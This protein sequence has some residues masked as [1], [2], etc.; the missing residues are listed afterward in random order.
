LK[1]T[2]NELS[3][4]PLSLKNGFG[5]GGGTGLNKKLLQS[6]DE[7]IVGNCIY[8]LKVK[9]ESIKSVEFK[10]VSEK[11]YSLPF[12]KV[13]DVWILKK[14]SKSQPLLLGCI[15]WCRFYLRIETYDDN[16]RSIDYSYSV[17]ICKDDM[18]KKI[19]CN[20]WTFDNVSYEHGFIKID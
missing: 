20:S 6:E 17:I 10:I 5:W 14:F 11:E 16:E 1:S 4:Q 3:I 15:T 7:L 9:G 18:I 8:D 2:I 19:V 13:N 12:D